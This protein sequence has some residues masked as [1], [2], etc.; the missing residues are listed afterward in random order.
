DEAA[1]L[2]GD[3]RPLEPYLKAIRVGTLFLEL[4]TPRA[5]E[6][7][8]VS[9]LGTDHRIGLGCVNPRSDRVETVA[10]ITARA[11]A[12]IAAFGPDRVLLNS[13]CGF[14]TFADNPVAS[15]AVASAKL[16]AMAEASSRLR[17]KY[18]V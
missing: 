18:R 14:A 9:E 13:D 16:A 7:S 11:E 15:A 3:Y 12:A 1:L 6:V 4:S 2:A 5:G 17:D 10:E 8:A